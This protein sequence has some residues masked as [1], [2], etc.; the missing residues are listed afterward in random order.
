[1]AVIAVKL[2]VILLLS[3]DLQLYSPL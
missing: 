1:M 3:Y 2:T